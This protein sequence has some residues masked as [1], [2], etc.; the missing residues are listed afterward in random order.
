MWCDF[1]KKM[2]KM[3]TDIEKIT[4]DFKYFAQEKR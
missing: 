2:D 3:A 4:K 1:N